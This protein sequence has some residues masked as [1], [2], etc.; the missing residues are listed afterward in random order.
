MNGELIEAYSKIRFLE[1][2]VV[3]ENAKIER[4]S[5]KKLDDVI[6]SQKHFSDKSRLGYTGGSSSSANVTK[7]V[8]FVKAREPVVVA[9]TPEKVKDETKKNVADQRVLNKSRN[10]SVARTEAKGRLPPKS[11]RS[12]RTNHVCHYCGLQGHTRPNCHKLRALNNPRDQRSRAPRDDRRN[13]TVGQPRSQNED[14]GVMD[15]I[16]M[17]KAFTTCLANFNSRFEGHNSHT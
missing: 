1:L 11:Q 10:Q 2:E 12:S 4:V 13:W 16:K 9:F 5:T 6:S 8:K 15:V 7:E 14:S 17:I 3:Q